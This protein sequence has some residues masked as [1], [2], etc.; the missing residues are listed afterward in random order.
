[1]IAGAD[2]SEN[3]DLEFGDEI[4]KL[5]KMIQIYSQKVNPPQDFSFS[6]TTSFGAAIDI[7]RVLTRKVERKTVTYMR[8]NPSADKCM[9]AFYN[10]LSS[11]F[12][13]LRL[14]VD[15]TFKN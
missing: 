11:L 10:R 5:E 9:I 2:C 4:Q 1:M 13:V 7:C 14:F 15:Q 12:F 3:G 6:G 8:E